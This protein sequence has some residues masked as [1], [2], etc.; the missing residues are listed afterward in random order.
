MWLGI[1]PPTSR[2]RGECST[3]TLPGRS[4]FM[5]NKFSVDKKKCTKKSKDLSYT[6]ASKE[7]L[8]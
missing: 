8:S 5:L 2:M 1:E 7:T 6:N 4:N 3:T